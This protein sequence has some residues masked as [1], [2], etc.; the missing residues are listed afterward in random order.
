[1]PTTHAFV[2][3]LGRRI[4]VTQLTDGGDIG[5][6]QIVTEGFITLTLSS[7]IEAGTEILQRNAAGILCVNELLSPNFKR[8]NVEIEFCGVNP[9]LVAYVANAATYADYAGD[10]AGFTIREGIITGA[11]ALELWTGVGGALFDE[12]ANGYFLLPYVHRGHLGDIKVDGEKAVTF[13]LTEAYT[14]GGNSWGIGPYKVVINDDSPGVPDFLPAAIDPFDH[15]LMIDTAVA[16]P[17][18]ASSPAPIAA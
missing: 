9:S 5:T 14:V 15:L 7:Q 16:P 6:S 1:M 18:V 12:T 10:V 17:A 13:Q 11:F 3:F 2:P 4:R 8:F